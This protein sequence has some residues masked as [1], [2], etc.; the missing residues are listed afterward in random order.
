MA[1]G[2]KLDR[3]F[4]NIL[5]IL[6]TDARKTNLALSKEVNLSPSP[7]LERVKKLEQSGA[8]RQYR[9]DIDLD[10][11]CPNVQVFAEVTLQNHRTEDFKA[12][13]K[14]LKDIPEITAA[15]KISG[16]YDFML[17]LTCLDIKHYHDLSEEMINSDLG[18]AKF[19]GHVVLENTKPFSGYPLDLLVD[20]D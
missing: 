3:I 15:A 12:F 7:C 6:Q 16:P 5:R 20:T 17:S 8:V 18:I 10:A 9:C 2:L 14:A 4:L 13:S 19:I 1:T 11:I